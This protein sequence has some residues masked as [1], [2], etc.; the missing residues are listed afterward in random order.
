VGSYLADRVKIGGDV[1]VMGPSGPWILSSRDQWSGDISSE[2][3][4]WRLS[5]RERAR[6]NTMVSTHRHM[7][8][9]EAYWGE[10]WVSVK[11]L[12]HVSMSRVLISLNMSNLNITCGEGKVTAGQ[13][14][15]RHLFEVLFVRAM[16]SERRHI[17]HLK[18]H[19]SE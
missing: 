14:I 12:N 19:H 7:E 5:T 16:T 8:P 15:S 6:E 4:T 10:K 13:I 18:A 3:I 17:T 9:P 11:P 2:E 1:G